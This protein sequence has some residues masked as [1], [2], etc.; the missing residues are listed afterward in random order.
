MTA[1]TK[2]DYAGLTDLELAAR[3]LGRD[4]E[5]V[6]LITARHNQ[7]LFRTAWSVLS[8]RSDAEDGLQTAYLNAFAAIGGFEGR[9]SL[10]T[11]LTR[12]V[13]NEALLRKRRA[14]RQRAHL[15]RSSVSF[16]DDYREK[17]MRGSTVASPDRELARRELRDLLEQAIANLPDPFR[18]VFVLREIEGLSVEETAEVLGIKPATVKT[19]LVRAKR[20]L[21][22]ALAPDLKAS[23]ESIV[24]FAGADC[25]RMTE[26]VMAAYCPG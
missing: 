25:A 12:I 8:S 18:T 1:Q 23:L 14:D 6:R 20:R 11:W 13:L 17:L 5:A 2:I 9:S 19:R 4:A 26:N 22:E 15:S 3:I 24:D 16:I 7:R 21:Q 10:A